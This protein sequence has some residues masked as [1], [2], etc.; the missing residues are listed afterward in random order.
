MN[1][2]SYFIYYLIQIIREIM[3]RR[4]RKP[5]FLF[6]FHRVKRNRRSVCTVNEHDDELAYDSAPEID[7]EFVSQPQETSPSSSDII[8]LSS[9][10]LGQPVKPSLPVAPE[11][12]TSQRK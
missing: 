1:I 5:R 10:S 9:T 3:E 4:K 6:S 11:K 8:G 7:T 2:V 12:K